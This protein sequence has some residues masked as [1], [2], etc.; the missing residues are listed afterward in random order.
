VIHFAAFA[1][2]GES[3]T[4]PLKYYQNN[5][6]EPVKLL[7][8][9]QEFGCKVFV[10]SSTCATYGVPDKLPI[11]ENNTQN[12]INPYGRSKLMVEWI[13]GLRPRLGPA[14]RLPAVFQRQRLLGRT[15]KSARITTRKPT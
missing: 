14:Q 15:A 7:Q 10:F 9:M 4:D 2:V 1:Y 12:P 3:V 11:T 13:L 8:V 5:T 6:A